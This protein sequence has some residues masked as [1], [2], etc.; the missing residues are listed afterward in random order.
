MCAFP[1]KEMAEFHKSHGREGSIVVSSDIFGLI[2]AVDSL[3]FNKLMQKI[4]TWNGN[5]LVYSLLIFCDCIKRLMLDEENCW[6]ILHRAEIKIFKIIFCLVPVASE[7]RGHL[8]DKIGLS[9]VKSG[10][11]LFV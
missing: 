2:V 1:F 8:A 5:A 6:C 3:S 11:F 10:S 7:R 4:P 9:P